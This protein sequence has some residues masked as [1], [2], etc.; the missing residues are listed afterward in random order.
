[1]PLPVGTP[2]ILVHFAA[3]CRYSVYTRIIFDF[4]ADTR[5][6]R[7]ITCCSDDSF[8]FRTRKY[9]VSRRLAS[10]IMSFVEPV[11][12]DNVWLAPQPKSVASSANASRLRKR[13]EATISLFST[14]LSR[15]SAGR[16]LVLFSPISAPSCWFGLNENGRRSVSNSAE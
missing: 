2:Y 10:K 13:V 3:P 8:V 9:V 5:S 14:D 15:R 12:S 11:C 7:L 16:S 1:M 6:V 4:N